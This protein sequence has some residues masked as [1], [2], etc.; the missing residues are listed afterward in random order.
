MGE[1]T[2]I[3]RKFLGEESEAFVSVRSDSWEHGCVVEMVISDGFNFN[4]F[5]LF[6]GDSSQDPDDQYVKAMTFLDNLKAG[7]LAAQEELVD[8]YA[9]MR[10]S[11]LDDDEREYAL[12]QESEDHITKAEQEGEANREV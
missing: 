1:H 6:V 3:F 4:N 5:S 10:F 11:S 9:D 12:E 8:A 2:L 7:V